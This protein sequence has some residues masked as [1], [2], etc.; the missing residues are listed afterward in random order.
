MV[1]WL[2]LKAVSSMERKF[3]YD[4]GYLRYLARH[5]AAAF[6]KFAMATVLS[7]HRRGV[8]PEAWH[9]AKITTAKAEDCGPC[10]QLLVDM[11]LKD[12]IAPDTVA[13]ILKDDTAAMGADAAVG[14]RLAR[15]VVGHRHEDHDLAISTATTRWGERGHAVLAVAITGARLYPT[16]KAG[17]GYSRECRQLTVA[18]HSVQPR[19]RGTPQHLS[20]HASDSGKKAPPLHRPS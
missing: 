10:T 6:R 15:A 9:A 2:L 13:A 12:G 7:F 20:D 8:P 1:T 18:G 5:D 14:W 16:L 19:R 3:A 17:L 11:A 4:A